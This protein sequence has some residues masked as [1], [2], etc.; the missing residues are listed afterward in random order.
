MN[1]ED[2]TAR[3]WKLWEEQ[4]KQLRRT[5]AASLIF[6]IVA[7]FNIIIPYKGLFSKKAEI[8]AQINE[9]QTKIGDSEAALEGLK[10]IDTVMEQVEKILYSRAWDEKR[11]DLIQAYSRLNR[12]QRGTP[13]L[14]QS[15]ADSTVRSI[16]EEVIETVYEPL[17]PFLDRNSNMAVFAPETFKQ[18]SLLSETMQAW[19]NRYINKPW[20]STRDTKAQTINELSDDLNE[21]LSALSRTLE[22]E[23]QQLFVNKQQLD[24]DIQQLQSINLKDQTQE[25]DELQNRMIEVLPSWMRGLFSIEQL[26]LFFPHIIAGILLF[27]IWLGRSLSGHFAAATIAINDK[28]L[29]A[30]PAFSSNWTLIRRTSWGTL[31]TVASYLLYAAAM[32]AAFEKG[33]SVLRESTIAASLRDS[34]LVFSPAF[35]WTSRIAIIV[36]LFYVLGQRLLKKTR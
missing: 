27:V 21:N 14:Y 25:L 34:T 13:E 18:A 28:D 6:A 17:K 32:I 10:S 29:I 1:K 11:V 9:V 15:M 23:R 36:S 8:A 22:K 7:L 26:A 35:F 5:V 24:D 19:E 31:Q 3:H 30:D 20:Y 2:I 12:Q 16:T 33:L 4:N